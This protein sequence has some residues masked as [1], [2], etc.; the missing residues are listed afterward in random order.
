MQTAFFFFF[1]GAATAA[2]VPAMEQ[3][4]AP[5]VEAGPADARMAR[6][7]DGEHHPQ[8]A[9]APRVAYIAL[10]GDTLVGYIGGHLSQRYKCHGELQYLYV[11]PQNRRA[12]V[13][14][15]LLRRLA[16]WFGEHD[17]SRVCV[18]ADE[19]N[20]GALA[21]LAHHGAA[22]HTSCFLVWQDISAVLS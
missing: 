2:D 5:D 11:V 1:S 13:A 3:A 8:K 6:Y 22:N 10:D 7:L 15:E 16:A 17:A 19:E 14:T 21:F 12:G 18:G 20:T 9:L 4:R